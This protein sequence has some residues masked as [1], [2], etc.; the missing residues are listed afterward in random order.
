MYKVIKSN[1]LVKFRLKNF[2][3]FKFFGHRKERMTTLLLR[4]LQISKRIFYETHTQV[5]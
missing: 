3:F 1:R 5:P 2:P 4:I